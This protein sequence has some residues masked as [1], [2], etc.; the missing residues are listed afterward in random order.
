MLA[1]HVRIRHDDDLI[2]AE[3]SYVKVISVAFRKAAAE[4]L[5][6]GLYLRVCQ[7]LIYAGLLHI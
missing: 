5:H 4:G 6:H 2:V 3:L 1:V 7:N